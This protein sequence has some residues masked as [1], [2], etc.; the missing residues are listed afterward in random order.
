MAGLTLVSC[1]INGI[2][3]AKKRNAVFEWFSRA[4]YDIIF[5]QETHCCLERQ[6]RLWSQEWGGMSL[7]SKGTNRSRGVAVLFKR[8]VKFD[9]SN[10]SL[11]TDGRYIVFDIS[12]DKSKYHLVNIYAP[13]NG[14]ER[15]K[16]FEK[17]S[18]F[19]ASDCE[20]LLAGDF[21]CTL[22]NQ[23]DR[24]NCT[25]MAD[26]GQAQLH[27][28][29]NSFDLED[30]WRRRNPKQLKFSWQ[31]RD[32][33]SR[34]DFWIISK[35][36]DNQIDVT[37]YVICPFSDHGC[38]KLVLRTAE[39]KQGQGIW[40]MNEKVIKSHL[41]RMA[42][43]GF[44]PVWRENRK[45]YANVNQWWDLGKKKIKD[46]AIRTSQIL[47][48]EQSGKIEVLEKKLQNLAN[49][50]DDAQKMVETEE[51]KKELARMYEQKAEGAKIRARVSWFEEGE[52]STHYFH[53]LEVRRGKEKA[54]S[55]IMDDQQNLVTGTS[56]IMKEQVKFY[57]EL[58][59]AE[60]TDPDIARMFLES[61]DVKISDGHNCMLEQR[62]TLE[63]LTATVKQMKNNKSPGSDGIISEFYKLYWD[64]LKSDLLDVFQYS[65]ENECLPHTQNIAVIRL[66]FKKGI[67][68]DIRNWR[69]ISLLNTDVKI[70]SKLLANRLKK[71]LPE[72]IHTDQT[73]C[74][75][76]RFIG[77]NIRLMQDIIDKSESDETILLL[78]QEK[79]FD[80]VDHGWLFQVLEQF[81]LPSKYISWF[82]ILYKEMKSCIL[83]NGY[84]S[85]HFCLSRGIRQGD[86]LSAL[87]YVLQAE[88]FACY[89]RKK[90]NLQGIKLSGST[91]AK[92]SQYVDDTVLYLNSYNMVN[93]SLEIIENFGKASGSRL[94]RQKT[95]CLVMRED[96][97]K[98]LGEN[99]KVTLGPVKL[100]GI[101]LGKT[102][103]ENEFWDDIIKKIEKRYCFWKMRDLSLFGKVHVI[104]SLGMSLVLYASNMLYL[105]D[106]NIERITKINYEFLWGG[107]R[108]LM[109]K[110]ICI[111]P[112]H[113]GGLGMIDLRIAI[114]AQRIKWMKRILLSSKDEKWAC[115]PTESFKCLD[116][117][118]G[119]DL[120]AVRVSDSCNLLDKTQCPFFYKKV[121]L[122]MQE[123][124]RKRQATSQSQIVWCNNKIKF[125]GQPLAF[126]HWAKCGVNYL[127][128]IVENGTYK[129][130][131]LYRTILDKRSY[132]F[133]LAKLKSAIPLEML[134]GKDMQRVRSVNE[135]EEVLDTR[136]IVSKQVEKSLNELT[137]KEIYGM[138]LQN[139]ATEIKSKQYWV[140]K[141]N[142]PD[143][144]FDKWFA[145]NFNSNIIPRKCVDFNWKVFHGRVSTETTL[146]KMKLSDG[147]CTI[148]KTVQE[149]VVHLLIFCKDN[150]IVWTNIGNL[151]AKYLGKDFNISEK[152]ILCGILE[153][154][155]ESDM[156]NLILSITR[157][158]IWKRRNR[159][160][161]ENSVIGT[162]SCINWI[163]AEIKNH[164]KI[165]LCLRRILN[166]KTKLKQLRKLSDV[167]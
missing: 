147:F 15:I 134:M 115:I 64:D 22:D 9:I 87:F 131:Y 106:K 113:Q 119:I 8:N 70:L 46:I 152:I 146:Q 137:T 5:L 52:R 6:E 69:P 93:D 12:V 98:S 25:G 86:S 67:R 73:G 102:S 18:D 101:P 44:W 112:R 72:I 88:P 26:R 151:I 39:T 78:D 99:M 129:E 43:K 76:G 156:I 95:E 7:W 91:E 56:N 120:F 142:E 16:F 162:T 10:V 63:E 77:Q 3:C 104:K 136:F 110:E 30:V 160:K 133:D 96:R 81:G 107:K 144:D 35:S 128:D 163:V 33:A 41:F 42:F 68:E 90:R 125:N 135:Y 31:R 126:A 17:L 82:K 62:L 130:E 79:A 28:L 14:S 61:V 105:S 47:R 139:T 114:K 145:C 155:F 29:I 121:L 66:L 89:I 161:Y 158:T 111:L 75:E 132:V 65:Y 36:L 109:K 140:N 57:K 37:D 71:V 11:D 40:K 123:L 45:K 80:R 19:I 153:K 150:D 164:V 48:N 148:C 84:V 141:F 49:R 74:I 92:I 55:K 50:V 21:N 165:L 13:N 4:R 117:K 154:S 143:L 53:N 27:K 54:W 59:K 32:K 23:L 166:D 167:L 122:N 34:I 157:Y 138:F 159:A 100:L 149:N 58:Y 60:P 124:K 97:L 51:V 83:T 94:N 118:F 20:N 38:A 116:T 2:N 24:K 85:E 127:E 103:N 108:P 1:N